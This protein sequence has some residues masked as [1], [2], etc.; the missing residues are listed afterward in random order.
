MTCAVLAAC[1]KQPTPLVDAIRAA[2]ELRVATVTS[3]T[4]FYEGSRGATGFEHDLSVAFARWLGV[5]PSF[6]VARDYAELR[7]LV[8]DNRAHIGAALLPVGAAGPGDLR[9]G[10]S[11]ATAEQLVVYRRGQPRPRD[12][13]DLAGRRGAA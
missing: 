6:R 3:G 7:E 1:G 10:P 2:G 13:A 11:Y 5:R 12:A 4:T 8:A 9:F